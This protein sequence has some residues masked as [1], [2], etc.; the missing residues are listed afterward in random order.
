[1][2]RRYLFIRGS[3]MKKVI[4]S[5]KIKRVLSFV[6]FLF[7]IWQVFVHLTYLF[8]GADWSAYNV[9]AYRNEKKD[10]IDVVLVGGSSVYRFWNPLQAYNEHGFTSYDYTSSNFPVPIAIGAMEELKKR[11]IPR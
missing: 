6:L 8:R 7:L 11:R 3:E 1:M 10:S 9:F 4:Q 5:G 2:T